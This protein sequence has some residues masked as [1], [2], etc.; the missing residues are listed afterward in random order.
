MSIA[1]SILRGYPGFSPFTLVRLS[2]VASQHGDAAPNTLASLIINVRCN[3]KS[4]P[5]GKTQKTSPYLR[6]SRVIRAYKHNTSLY[7]VYNTND[8]LTF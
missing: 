5:V 2:E 1:L 8:G 3:G 6:L 4:K 7:N